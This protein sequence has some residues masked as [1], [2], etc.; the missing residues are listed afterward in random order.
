MQHMVSTT[1]STESELVP[2]TKT[3]VFDTVASY[4]ALP[5]KYRRFSSGSGCFSLGSQSTISI[6][7]RID[8][9]HTNT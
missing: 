4:E 5:V 6:T 3:A 8:T 1:T 2:R 9:G 7:N